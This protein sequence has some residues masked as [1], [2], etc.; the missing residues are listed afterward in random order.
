M[1]FHHLGIACKDLELAKVWVSRMHSIVKEGKPVFDPLQNATLV[2]LHTAEGL[3]IEMISG[4]QVQHI[5][6]RGTNFYHICYSVSTIDQSV[7]DLEGKG[8]IVISSPKPAV[9][10][11]GR[12]VAFLHTPMGMIE[13][14]ED[15]S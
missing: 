15:E 14:L 13:L 5:V 11:D 9:L 8:A 2:L 6:K 12:K 4:E 3:L 7:K 1:K 10:F